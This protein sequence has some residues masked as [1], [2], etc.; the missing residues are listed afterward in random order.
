MR[1]TIVEIIINEVCAYA[2]GP[3]QRKT[4]TCF[5]SHFLT[6]YLFRE[7]V[8]FFCCYIDA[9]CL[10]TDNLERQFFLLTYRL[11]ICTTQQQQQY[12][13][14]KLYRNRLGTC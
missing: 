12:S 1:N 8:R 2:R 9:F 13:I 5:G 11:S 3:K 4:P 10:N 7:V 6:Q 14:K